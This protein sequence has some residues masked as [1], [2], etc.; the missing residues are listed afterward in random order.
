MPRK[1]GHRITLTDT[2]SG[3]VAAVP[4]PGGNFVEISDKSDLK[5]I[6]ALIKKRQALGREITKKLADQGLHTAGNE[7]T[8]VVVIAS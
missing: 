6:R 4:G 2:G 5:A 3:L 1:K 7:D 8:D